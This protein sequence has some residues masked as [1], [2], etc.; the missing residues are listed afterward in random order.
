M[1]IGG[2]MIRE[3][4]LKW[5]LRESQARKEEEER[6]KKKEVPKLPFKIQKNF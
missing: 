6:A 4:D 2:R 3:E 1:P 5:N